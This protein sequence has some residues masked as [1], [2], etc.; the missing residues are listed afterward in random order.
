M[1][2]SRDYPWDC[3]A[4]GFF[5][6]VQDTLI[7][8]WCLERTP[9][10][11]WWLLA[12]YWVFSMD[13]GEG[14]DQ[15]LGSQPYA[16]LWWALEMKAAS[17]GLRNSRFIAHRDIG[18]CQDAAACVISLTAFAK[19][20]PQ[21]LC[22]GLCQCWV[23]ERWGGKQSSKELCEWGDTLKSWVVALHHLWWISY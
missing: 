7:W 2:Y 8:E 11:L 4:E 3:C 14:K 16:P 22:A 23:C 21:I 5:L 13:I 15:V 9:D 17:P 19:F 20:L 10:S 1:T 18:V 12:S 6:R